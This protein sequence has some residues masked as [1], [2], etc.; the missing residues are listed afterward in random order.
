M[1]D[2]GNA[3]GE[4]GSHLKKNKKK[5]LGGGYIFFNPICIC[6]FC[7]VMTFYCLCLK[8]RLVIKDLFSKT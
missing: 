8:I 7:S 6:F 5:N 4:E 1:V 3:V 2:H